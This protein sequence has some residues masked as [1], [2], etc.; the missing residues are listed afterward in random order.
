[1]EAMSCEVPVV[2]TDTEGY[3]EF[4]NKYLDS[5]K[6]SHLTGIFT[7]SL[8]GYQI[9]ETQTNFYNTYS[10]GVGRG[11]SSTLSSNVGSNYIHLY[12]LNKQKVYKADKTVY[13]STTFQR[14]Y[15]LEYVD[16]YIPISSTDSLSST[17]F[18]FGTSNQK[19]STPKITK[20]TVNGNTSGLYQLADKL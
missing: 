18:Y 3:K 13:Y 10:E 8:G 12:Y 20:I 6:I 9:S 5:F 4:Y 16:V 11:M 7:G 2:A 1:M 14:N 17:T 15:E 19:T